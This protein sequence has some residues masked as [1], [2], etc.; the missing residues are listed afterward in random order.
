VEGRHSGY[1]PDKQEV[2]GAAV[3]NRLIT[4]KLKRVERS[5]APAYVMGGVG[6]AALGVGLSFIGIAES[7]RSEA[8]TLSLETKHACAVSDPAPQ[9]Q[10]K[11]LASTASSGDTFGN[12]GIAAVAV[13]VTAVAGGVAYW[14]LSAPRDATH[15]ARAVRVLPTASTTGGG[16]FVV[17]SF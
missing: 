5:K 16:V 12:V 6:L 15:S 4:L 2:D 1:T 13:G 9:G 11:D 7:K 17:G 10:C 14:F 3:A 8:K